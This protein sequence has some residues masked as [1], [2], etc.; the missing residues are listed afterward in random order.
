VHSQSRTEL[1]ELRLGDSGSLRAIDEVGARILGFTSASECLAASHGQVFATEPDTGAALAVFDGAARMTAACR[2]PAGSRRCQLYAR[3]DGREVVALFAPLDRR[4]DEELPRSRDELDERVAV[5]TDELQQATDRLARARERAEALLRES[6]ARFRHLADALPQIVWTALPTGEIDYVNAPG[7]EYAGVRPE[8]AFEHGWLDFIHPEDAPRIWSEWKRATRW[9]D[10][11]DTEYRLRRHDGVYRWQLVRALPLRD[12]QGG[13][14]RWFGTSTDVEEQKLAQ[15]AMQEEDRRKN[16]F[17]AM[18]SHELRNPLTPVRN[19]VYLLRRAPPGSPAHDRAVTIVERQVALMVR[20]IDDLLDLSRITHGKILLKPER[21]DLVEVVRALLDDRS[22]S[23]QADGLLLV[24]TLPDRPLW[25]E[26]DVA[27]V[28]Q[29]VG[30]LLENAQR[31]TDRGGTVR[32]EAHAE[33]GEAVVLVQDSGLGLSREALQRIFIPF[34]QAREPVAGARGGLG[35]GLSL[36][37]SFAELHGGSVEARSEGEGRGSTFTLRIPLAGELPA[38]AALGSPPIS[39][40][41]FLR[42]RIL[43]VEDNPDA[44]ESLRLM[45]ELDGHHVEVVSSGEEGVVRARAA[46]PDIVLSDIGLP[47]ISGYD[48]ARALRAEPRLETHLVAVTGYGQAKDREEA[49]RSG[50]EHHLTK[51]FDHR[52]LHQ[53]LAELEPR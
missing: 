23:L 30:N 11:L 6:E 7:A 26:G 31:Y 20:L 47:G 12:A 32:I 22:E 38:T 21:F 19:A 49:L 16:D 43:I 34:V 14:V 33:Y 27:R 29:A 4:G 48:L 50:F 9:G 25:V 39:R 52:L 5:R 36:V 17:L 8:Q 45:L 28:A 3:G 15:Q 51:P 41:T 44:A 37:K 2:G 35:L 53:L 13:V 40:T 1:G 24:A 10:T 42:R 18:L 46:H